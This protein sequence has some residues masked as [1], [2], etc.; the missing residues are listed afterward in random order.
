MNNLD[1]FL[2][3]R[4]FV[5]GAKTNLET[6]LPYKRK[7]SPDERKPVCQKLISIGRPGTCGS[8]LTVECA[9]GMARSH[10]IRSECLSEM[11]N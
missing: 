8:G 3:C 10:A 7:H 9:T 5:R 1:V 4:Q 2:R 6:K 11:L